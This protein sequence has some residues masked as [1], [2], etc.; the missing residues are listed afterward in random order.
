MQLYTPTDI[1]Q[2]QQDL[3]YLIKSMQWVENFVGKAHPD[4]GRLGPVCPFVPHSIR[5]NVMSLTVIRAKN[6]AP[7]QFFENVLRCRDIF[8]E[9]E[10]RQGVA[11][12]RKTLLIIVPDID[13]EEAPKIIDENH[14]KLKR[15]FVESGLMIG[16]FHKLNQVPGA[17]NPN[18][19]P[20]QSSV[21]MFVIRYMV[22][23]DILFLQDED[24]RLRIKYLQAYLQNIE[25]GYSQQFNQKIKDENKLKTARQLLELAQEQLQEEKFM[26]LEIAHS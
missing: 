15:F 26:N 10:P 19:R 7:E 1:N 3:P 17:H 12:L 22:E 20:F 25:S 18:F 11:A 23:S 6:V 2:L 16:E 13:I 24:P 21:P 8:L 14:K 4:L 5:A 9:Q